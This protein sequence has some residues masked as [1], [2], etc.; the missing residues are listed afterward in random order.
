MA[1]AS[2]PLC[3]RARHCRHARQACTLG[4]TSFATMQRDER[5]GGER[6]APW[7]PCASL[8]LHPAQASA[9]EL[10]REVQQLLACRG[11]AAHVSPPNTSRCG[12]VPGVA[13][14]SPVPGLAQCTASDHGIRSRQRGP[15]QA[16]ARHP[17]T[18]LYQALC[19]ACVPGRDAGHGTGPWPW[20][21]CQGHAG[22]GHGPGPIHSGH[23][24][25][26]AVAMA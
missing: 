8:E 26:R 21:P 11:A 22:R 9:D 4:E 15:G 13:Q 6:A 16:C 17:P 20:P 3:G 19:T 23:S 14:V 2:P 25:H 18:L 1:H 24:W 7:A 5:A 12:P 10:S